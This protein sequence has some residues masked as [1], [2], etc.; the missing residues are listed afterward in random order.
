[1]S[2]WRASASPGV[3]SVILFI[4]EPPR[5]RPILHQPA[6]NPDPILQA[7]RLWRLA[8]LHLEATR[9][10][11]CSRKV[12]SR[13]PGRNRISPKASG[14]SPSLS[15]SCSS[16][17]M[18]S[19]Y[20]VRAWNH[21]RPVS[22]ASFRPACSSPTKGERR[23]R[24]SME[25]SAVARNKKKLRH[26]RR[27]GATPGRTRQA[28]QFQFSAARPSDIFTNRLRVFGGYPFESNS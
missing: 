21:A 13:K 7:V 3:G 1:M 27:R 24:R 14:S 26:Q 17:R 20:H 4:F 16:V 18:P 11:P 9:R 19:S 22:P 23:R 28:S 10:S 2:L 8:P 12:R 5:D 6:R 25:G 15:R